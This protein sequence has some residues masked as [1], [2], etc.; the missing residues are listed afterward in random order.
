[1]SR[2]EGA[3]GV[4][5][6]GVCGHLVGTVGAYAREPEGNAA[7]TVVV[8]GLSWNQ[9]PGGGPVWSER[10]DPAKEGRSL[11]YRATDVAPSAYRDRVTMH[12]YEVRCERGARRRVTSIDC[13]RAARST[14]EVLRFF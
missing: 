12:T 11:A 6:V 3:N 7:A 2:E 10:P 8:R 1:M 9:S 4:D 13:H 5:G 14:R